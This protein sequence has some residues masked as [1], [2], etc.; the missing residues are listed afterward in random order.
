ME[1]E[2]YITYDHF[3]DKLVLTIEDNREKKVTIIPWEQIKALFSTQKEIIVSTQ[4]NDYTYLKD[5]VAVDL[6]DL[7]S[8]YYAYE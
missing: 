8:F 6:D 3:R 1:K 2:I 4:D 5:I 7:S